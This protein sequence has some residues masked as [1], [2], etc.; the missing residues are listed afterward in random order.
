MSQALHK[1]KTV[2]AAI[3]IYS[4]HL[5]L[6]RFFKCALSNHIIVNKNIKDNTLVKL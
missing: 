1:S 4:P 2:M 3:K 5:L 6:S